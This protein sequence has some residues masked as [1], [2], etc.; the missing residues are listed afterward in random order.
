LLATLHQKGA[1]YL[2]QVKSNQKT[3]LEDFAGLHGALASTYS[4]QTEEKGHG[5]Y[6]KRHYFCYLLN[7]A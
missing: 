4:F 5:R 6:E 1:L 3:L 7:Q 2:V